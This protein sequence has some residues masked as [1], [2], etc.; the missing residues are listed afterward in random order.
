MAQRA[1]VAPLL[2]GATAA[3][4]DLVAFPVFGLMNL[5]EGRTSVLPFWRPSRQHRLNQP[6]LAAGIRRTGATRLLLPPALCDTLATADLPDTVHTI[7]TGG[8]PV[9][10]DTIARLRQGRP[11]LRLLSVYG[12]TEAEPIAEIDA[13]D[14]APDDIAAM[15]AGAGLLAGPPVAGLSL[16]LRDGEVQV[17]GAHV[18]K[19]Y[20]DPARDAES[21][22]REGGTVWHRT[23]DAGRLDDRG[24]L[25]LLGRHGRAVSTPQGP[26]HP[27]AVET[28]ARFWPGLRRAALAEV[29]G[30]AV[31]A[32]EGDATYLPEW[33][34]CAAEFGAA[35]VRH[36]RALPM[37]RRHRSKIDM[38]RLLRML[39]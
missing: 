20:L 35:T 26:L 5:A 28:A 4:R 15:R 23:G 36:L 1:A 34:R 25:W 32:V 18:N 37:D 10:P 14:I 29:G 24:R 7:L 12:S 16:R 11:D 30:A 8:G 39:G 17:A 31:L 33:Q 19:G 27:F 22:L 2:A 9:F 38:A 3:D 21:K 13:A 6:D